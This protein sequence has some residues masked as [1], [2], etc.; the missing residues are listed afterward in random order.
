[1]AQGIDDKTSYLKDILSDDNIICYYPFMVCHTCLEKQLIKLDNLRRL[2][3]KQNIIVLTDFVTDDIPLFFY[4][5]NIRLQ[6]YTLKNKLDISLPEETIVLFRAD[7]NRIKSSFVV[8]T[9]TE[10][11]DHYFYDQFK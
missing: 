5:N 2:G 6:L 3:K 7:K 9:Q 1:M 10:E 11:Y 8:N 4:K